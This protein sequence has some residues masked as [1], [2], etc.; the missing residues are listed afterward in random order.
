MQTTRRTWKSPTIPS[1]QRNCTYSDMFIISDRNTNI[2]PSF[3]S[4][5]CIQ[6]RSYPLTYS[7][8]NFPLTSLMH[9]RE[10]GGSSD[11]LT[12]GPSCSTLLCPWLCALFRK[13]FQGSSLLSMSVSSETVVT[14]GPK[15]CLLPLRHL[16]PSWVPGT[17]SRLKPQCR[18]E[19]CMI[20][21]NKKCMFDLCRFWPRALKT[22][23]NL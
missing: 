23:G 3:H 14:S 18:A 19:K 16:R 5:L 12:I 9:L 1:T 20:P 6:M 4:N 11:R 2:S 8:L 17:L 22:L 21:Y 10:P 13:H 7:Y 15:D